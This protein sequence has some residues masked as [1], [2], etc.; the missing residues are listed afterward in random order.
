M[1]KIVGVVEKM[2]EVSRGI[3]ACFK[4]PRQSAV[5]RQGD[6]GIPMI[7]KWLMERMMPVFH[8]SRRASVLDV[9]RRQKQDLPDTS[10]CHAE[11]WEPRSRRLCR[12]C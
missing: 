10:L 6:A 3:C 11:E 12:Q 4:N 5:P 2:Q 9:S 7:G 8:S 1:V